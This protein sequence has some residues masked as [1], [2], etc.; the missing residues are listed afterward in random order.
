[1]SYTLSTCFYTPEV[2]WVNIQLG[3]FLSDLLCVI[4]YDCSFLIMLAMLLRRTKYYCQSSINI[5]SNYRVW[6]K[7]VGDAFMTFGNSISTVWSMPNKCLTSNFSETRKWWICSTL[8][9]LIINKK[10]C[11]C[12][13]QYSP[14]QEVR[15]DDYQWLFLIILESHRQIPRWSEIR[16]C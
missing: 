7:T 16:E 14:L 4:W 2:H 6:G 10:C 8:L 3:S 15:P 1:M 11:V 9:H 5:P 13:V 12:E